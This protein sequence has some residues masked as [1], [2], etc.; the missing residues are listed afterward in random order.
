MRMRDNGDTDS[1]MLLN[2]YGFTYFTKFHYLLMLFWVKRLPQ[3]T[4]KLKDDMSQ[5]TDCCMVLS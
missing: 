2:G 5:R 4:L 3:D 1:I